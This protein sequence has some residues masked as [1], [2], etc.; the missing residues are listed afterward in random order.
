MIGYPTNRLLGVIDDP[1]R[2]RSVVREL[3]EAGIPATDVTLLEG[4]EA[5]EELRSLGASP[6][7]LRRV[8]RVFQYMTMDQ[9]PDFVMY[10][11]ALRDGRAL[12]AVRARNRRTVDR[13]RDVLLAADAHFV[14]WFG[15]L[16]T[17]EITQ[18]RGP[19]PDIPGYLKR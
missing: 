10:E 14:N 5:V 13:A 18:W 1:E 16:A 9:M 2:A 7:G 15:R 8:T 19:E 6:A 11:A 17:E 12:V 3:V 4:I